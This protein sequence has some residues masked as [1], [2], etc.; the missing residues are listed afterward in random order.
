M[1]G[2]FVAGV[3]LAWGV[4]ERQ[5][6]YNKMSQE[7]TGLHMMAGC[8]GDRKSR[9]GDRIAIASI[10]VVNQLPFRSRTITNAARTGREV[11]KSFAEQELLPALLKLGDKPKWVLKMPPKVYTLFGR[12]LTQTVWVDER[13]GLTRTR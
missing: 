11:L 1:I 8:G 9:T 2:M 7:A 12:E 3:F 10:H 4:M 6:K 5:L 13:R